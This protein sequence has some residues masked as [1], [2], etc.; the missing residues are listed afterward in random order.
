MGHGLVRQGRTFNDG[1]Y[2]SLVC[3]ISARWIVSLRAGLRW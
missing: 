3:Q 1:L 2:V